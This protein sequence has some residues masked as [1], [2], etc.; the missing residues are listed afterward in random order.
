MAEVPNAT[1]AI[2]A[3]AERAP[4]V[5]IMDLNMPGMP[6]DEA[7]RR[8]R[9]CDP[10]A[11]VVVLTVSAD[12]PDMTDAI[13]SGAAGYVLKDDLPEHIVEAVRAAAADEAA[14]SPRAASFC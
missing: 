14:I 12:S 7:I 13:L 4:D 10:G 2:A 3:V 11:R 6:G 1:A 9:L 8:L 5:V